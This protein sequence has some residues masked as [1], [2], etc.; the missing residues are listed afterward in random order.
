[1]DDLFNALSSDRTER[2][3]SVSVGVVTGQTE[4]ACPNRGVEEAGSL[5]PGSYSRYHRRSPDFTSQLERGSRK[6]LATNK[7]ASTLPT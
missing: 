7:G 1:M 4:S 6:R 5:V 2:T 3:A